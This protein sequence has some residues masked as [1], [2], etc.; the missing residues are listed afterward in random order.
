MAI[1]S[2][3]ALSIS[4]SIALLPPFL[5]LSLSLYL[6]LSLPPSLSVSPSPISLSLSL[7]RTIRDGV[8][9]LPREAETRNGGERYNITSPIY[10]EYI[11]TPSTE[12]PH[13][14]ESIF[15]TGLINTHQQGPTLSA[16]FDVLAIR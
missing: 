2:L 1:Q 4:L 5:S 13:I 8:I 12:T 10:Y 9:D 6:S 16:N 11:C 3:L 7:A 15:R 14:I